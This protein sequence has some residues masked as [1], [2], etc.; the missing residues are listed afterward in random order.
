MK[1]T[2]H[3]V[4]CAY[5]GNKKFD[6]PDDIIKAIEEGNL[7]LF[8]GAGIS[9]E[10][11]NLYSSSLYSEIND[12]LGEK[13]DNSFPKLMTKYCNLPNGRRKLISK[14]IKRFEYYKDFT[15]IDNHMNTFLSLCLTY[16]V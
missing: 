1:K 13:N 16:I 7:V 8:A 6:V 5:C 15:E 2:R 12:E 9:T 11:K 10:G 3:S 4:K 14:I